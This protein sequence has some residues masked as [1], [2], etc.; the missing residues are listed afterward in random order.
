MGALP[1]TDID[2]P[3]NNHRHM[4]PLW[5]LYP[6]NDI[7]PADTNILPLQKFSCNGAAM[8]TLPSAN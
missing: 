1:I 5:A 2:K 3:N 4:S 6:S 7:T 8:A